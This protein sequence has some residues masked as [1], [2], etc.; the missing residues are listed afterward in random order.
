MQSSPQLGG[1]Y[2]SRTKARRRDDISH[3]GPEAV[4]A[5][6]DGEMDAKSAHRFR[7]HLVHCQ[8]C[9]EE[10]RQHRGASHWIRAHNVEE[11]LRAPR[12]LLER[13]ANIAQTEPGTPA[14]G[15]STTGDGLGTDTLEP[16]AGQQEPKDFLDKCEM[17]IRA[18]QFN[19]RPRDN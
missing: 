8:E 19:Q 2:A 18:I 14:A 15:Q 13:L 12:H 9:R 17:V 11:A 16:D 1:S 3:P 10:I 4:A 5:F 7:K 6:V